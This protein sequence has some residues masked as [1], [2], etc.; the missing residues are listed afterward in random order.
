M[1]DQGS[2]PQDPAVAA[3]LVER[4]K[5][6]RRAVEQEEREAVGVVGLLNSPFM[7][8]GAPILYDA[9]RAREEA[10]AAAQ[11]RDKTRRHRK[12]RR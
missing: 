1:D 2:W 8:L 12:R 9:A 4:L 6:L 5:Q 11:R 7:P 3:A 10:R